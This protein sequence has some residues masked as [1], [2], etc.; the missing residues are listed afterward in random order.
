M[1]HLDGSYEAVLPHRIDLE[2]VKL[3]P[4][5]SPNVPTTQG[6]SL[7]ESKKMP[8]QPMEPHDA[9]AKLP[10]HD[11]RFPENRY[12]VGRKMFLENISKHLCRSSQKIHETQESQDVVLE[13]KLTHQQSFAIWA[14]N[15]FG[16]TQV[17]RQFAKVYS[18]E[19]PSIL[20]AFADTQAKIIESYST[21]A[22]KLGLVTSATEI[23]MAA[24]LLLDWYATT[25]ELVV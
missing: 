9:S 15:G 12:F 18:K 19:F 20:W 7:T 1:I 16:K 21:Y 22:V 4:E 11:L 8:T 3:R 14:P 25:G 23:V 2:R 10:L 13:S 5:K 17:A 6:T 24:R